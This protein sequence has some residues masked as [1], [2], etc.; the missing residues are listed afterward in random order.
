[1]VKI[2]VPKLVPY[3]P[4]IRKLGEQPE[5]VQ[6]ARV[7]IWGLHIRYIT[8]PSEAVQLAVVNEYPDAIKYINNPTKKVALSAVQMDGSLL[9]YISE[10]LQT[11][12]LVLEALI[13]DPDAKDY[14]V[15]PLTDAMI[16]Q[17]T[18]NELTRGI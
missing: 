6:L 13:N 7:S 14:I 8:N 10:N 4:D 9:R 2:L 12:E 17:M 18:L 16:A 11:E 3:D 1:M 5:D 15:V